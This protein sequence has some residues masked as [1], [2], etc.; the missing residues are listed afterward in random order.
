MVPRTY[1]GVEQLAGLFVDAWRHLRPPS[2]DNVVPSAVSG[3][4]R[5]ATGGCLR[6]RAGGLLRLGAAAGR[7][8]GEAGC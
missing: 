6:H 4:K 8:W 1:P 5:A 7:E 2:C 3:W